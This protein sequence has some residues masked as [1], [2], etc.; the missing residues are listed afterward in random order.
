MKRLI[1]CA[2]AVCLGSSGL[3]A[4]A[5][6]QAP[7]AQTP[8]AQAPSAQAPSAQAPSAQAPS[9]QAAPGAA[10][11]SEDEFFGS[12]DVEAKQGTAEKQGVAD[13]VE[14]EHVGLS[15]QL[16][17]Q[18]TYSM[19]RNF[20]QGV[21]KASD[22][23]FANLVGGDFLVDMRLQKG[24]KAFLD[25][26]LGFV[27]GGLPT[28]HTITP[29]G[30]PYATAFGPPPSTL[31]F[32][33]NQDT[34]LLIKEVFVDFNVGN[35]VYFRAGKQV[36]KWG[37][38]YFW[39]PT[40]LIN[41]EHRS[42]T[43]TN[44]LLD[45]VFGLRSDVVFSPNWHLYT[46]LNLNNVVDITSTAFAAR[47]EFLVGAT[48]FAGSAWLK[49]GRLPVFG[50]DLSTPL[51]WKLNLTGEG[52]FSWGDNQNK[53]DTAGNPYSVQDQLVA[54]IDVGLSRTFDLLDV[55]DRVSVNV[56][57]FWNSD[58]YNQNMFDLLTPLQLGTFFG[59]GYFQ[60]GYY[61]QYY[62]AAFVTISDFGST[63][64][65]LSLSGLANLSDLSGTALVGLSYSPVN[66]FTLSLQL[67]ADLGANNREYTISFNPT[68]FAPTNNQFFGIFG[69]TV[70]F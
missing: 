62:S 69:A 68:T 59:G 61:G 44:A 30:W 13:V 20:V 63:N 50:A 9:A 26:N 66:N 18:S 5:E 70:N 31:T 23:S 7:S 58:G 46:F 57:F 16:Q 11:S 42:F 19:T 67:G 25:L 64:M 8:S 4:Q 60:S 21:T 10:T 37:T 14:K 32:V 39:N 24:F 55:Q 28:S 53:L 49:S 41:I 38:G 54:K 48:E 1:V 65:T 56:E 40:D 3:F 34:A 27:P 45:G 33:E 47:S 36:L 43:N 52:A 2:L 35:T 51:F 12:A 6:G 22:N 29:A 17:A 15:G